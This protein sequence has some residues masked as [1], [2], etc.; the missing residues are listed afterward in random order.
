MSDSE[1][2]VQHN[3]RDN[4][5]VANRSNENNENLNE[6]EIAAQN[7]EVVIVERAPVY[8]GQRDDNEDDIQEMED[9]EEQF[10]QVFDLEEV[11]LELGKLQ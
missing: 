8:H 1:E 7:D 4:E 9:E 10:Q 11:E 2:Q 6:N 3:A 5:A